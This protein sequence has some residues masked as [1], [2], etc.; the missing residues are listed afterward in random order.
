[1][2]A[3]SFNPHSDPVRK[4]FYE[5][6]HFFDEETDSEVHIFKKFINAIIVSNNLF[7]KG[8]QKLCQ[9]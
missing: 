2:D 5:F 8:E 1:M 9:D 6:F 3:E 4:G 7:K